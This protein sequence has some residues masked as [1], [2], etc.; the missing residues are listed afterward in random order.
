MIR[1]H[2]NALFV[3]LLGKRLELDD[4]RLGLSWLNGS[5]GIE[6][7][8]TAKWSQCLQ[9]QSLLHHANVFHQDFLSLFESYGDLTEFKYVG[10]GHQCLRN[11]GGSHLKVKCLDSAI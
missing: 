2:D 10:V 1:E 11:S 8:E 7:A 6:H 3:N 4:N 9:A 5:H